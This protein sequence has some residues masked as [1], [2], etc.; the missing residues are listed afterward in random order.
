M[1]VDNLVI[2]THCWELLQC[3]WWL[4]PQSQANPLWFL[5]GIREMHVLS[6]DY[7]FKF[8]QLVS[9][10]ITWS[11]LLYLEGFVF[12]TLKS[13]SGKLCYLLITQ[14]MHPQSCPQLFVLSDSDNVHLWLVLLWHHII[15]LIG[16]LA[17]CCLCV[18]TVNGIVET[19][20]W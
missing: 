11:I 1:L 5:V 14:Q 7:L 2:V 6:C 8:L 15:L 18:E 19:T 4:R 20:V 16:G 10:I 13:W 12:I 17:S 9:K 3:V